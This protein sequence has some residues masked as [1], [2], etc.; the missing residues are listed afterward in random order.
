MNIDSPRFGKL[1]VEPAKI[2]EFPQGLAGFETY[3]RYSLFHPEG[4]DVK[5][6]ILQ[7]I[8]DPSLAFHIADPAQLGFNFEVVLSDAEVALLKLGDPRDSAV[9]V[10]LWKDEATGQL[11]A[12]L[13]APLIINIRERLGLQ[14]IFER[15]D[16]PVEPTAK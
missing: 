1:K 5:F 12:N 11:G 10:I 6:F 7:S 13:K 9:A 4:D 14:H 15:L 2:I 8:D 3:R 16:Y